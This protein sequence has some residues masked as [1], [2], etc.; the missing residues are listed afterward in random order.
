MILARQFFKTSVLPAVLGFMLLLAPDCWSLEANEIVVVANKNVAGSWQLAQY[1]LQKRNIPNRNLLM[2]SLT[3]Q[4]QCSREEYQQHVALP[5]RNYLAQRPLTA[6][7]IKCIV[8]VYG[9]PLVV[10]DSGLSLRQKTTLLE[11]HGELEVLRF[12]RD[13][14]SHGDKRPN[15]TL[16]AKIQT[17]E[18][19]VIAIARTT[20]TA[21]LDSELA[22]V[23]E[24]PYPLA[25]WLPNPH[26]LGYRQKKPM[27]MPGTALMVSRLDGPSVATVIRI[28][29]DSL[30]AE[31]KGL[32]GIAYFDARWPRPGAK[33]QS[34]YAAYDR[35]IHEAA[36]LVKKSRLMPVVLDEK[37]QLFRPGQCPDAA[38]YCGWYSLGK[39]VDAFR[40]V[41][42]A[43]A[44]HIASRECETL[45]TPGSTVWCKVM[46]EKGVAATL[47]PVTEPYVQAFP[48]PELFFG[49][50]TGGRFTLAECFA[51]SNPYLSWQMVL[52]GDPLYR[53]FKHPLR[54][55]RG[56][57]NP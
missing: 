26:F 31:A 37:E 36:G 27:S 9:V 48:P 44:Y 51:L 5:V 45:R 23:L 14:S 12:L 3:N 13:Y 52:I 40:W 8:T 30:S 53:P 24:K 22:L 25:G 4:E 32:H 42:G 17:R 54:H 28:I 7:G 55:S 56:G 33:E 41:T 29:D 57:G 39:Y 47:G 10:A 34:G 20:M 6:P 50:L 1:Y 2:L 49:L 15:K 18:G 21:A 19:Q 16:A 38:L 43:V 46:L 35:S 11:L